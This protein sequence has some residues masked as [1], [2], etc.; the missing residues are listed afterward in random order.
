M[1]K[2]G[3]G[4]R[5]LNLF[6]TL[7]RLIKWERHLGSMGEQKLINTPL[8]LYISILLPGHGPVYAYKLNRLFEVSKGFLVATVCLLQIIFCWQKLST[9]CL[10]FAIVRFCLHEVNFNNNK[11]PWKAAVFCFCEK[12][13]ANLPKA[14]IVKKLV[15]MVRITI[16]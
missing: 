12:I 5:G 8:Q 9:K 14:I 16:F 7:L 4:T 2:A 15:Q 3:T 6:P 13:G 11:S 1:H 10:Y